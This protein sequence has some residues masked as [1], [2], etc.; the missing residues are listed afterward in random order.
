MIRT[1]R[2]YAV[3]VGGTKF[4]EVTCLWASNN[5]GM[6]TIFRWGKIGHAGENTLIWSDT[7]VEGSDKGRKKIAAKTKGGYTFKNNSIQDDELEGFMQQFAVQD[8]VRLRDWF[9]A[10][11]ADAYMP[12]VP[13]SASA[14]VVVVDRTVTD[15]QW[16]TW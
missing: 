7:F 9:I 14:P 12:V 16:G 6:W 2:Q 5:H 13:S 8:A 15:D 1:S 3:H 11:K 4:Y 10:N